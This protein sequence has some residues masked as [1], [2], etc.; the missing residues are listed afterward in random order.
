[1]IDNP[2]INLEKLSEP[3]TKLTDV[4]SKGIGALYSPYGT[5]KQ[6]KA[7]AKAKIIQAKADAEVL[8]IEDRAKRRLLYHEVLRQENIESI[9]SQ[10]ALELPEVVSKK[11]L[12][13]DWILQYFDHIQDVCDKDMQKLW[14]RILSGEV[15]EPS[16]YSKRTLQFLKT[17]DKDEAE[18]FSY[19]CSYVLKRDS[20]WHF[21]CVDSLEIMENKQ[22][23][24]DWLTHFVSIGLISTRMLSW[25]P[26]KMSGYLVHYFDEIYTL[27]GPKKTEAEKIQKPKPEKFCYFHDFTAIGQELAKIAS[28]MKVV[29]FPDKL[30][31]LLFK[32]YKLKL[33]RINDENRKS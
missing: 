22:D 21:V 3:L 15:A 7:D 23:D 19:F 5:V 17:L 33:V 30:S 4:V 2:L 12:D 8:T 16:S 11:S 32:E 14:A 9:V 24:T 31:D 20:G 26:S 10:A 28:A 13:N 29:K 1:M 6:A 27:D 25:M 18:N